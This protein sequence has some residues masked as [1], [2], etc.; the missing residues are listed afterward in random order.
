MP[1]P[2]ILSWFHW[3][4]SIVPLALFTLIALEP[5]DKTKFR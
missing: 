4:L 5:G 1:V 3:I 2:N